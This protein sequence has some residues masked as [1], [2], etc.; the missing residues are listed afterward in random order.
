M[1]IN[2]KKSGETFTILSNAFGDTME[3]P[4]YHENLTTD[5]DFNRF[6]PGTSNWSTVKTFS[7]IESARKWMAKNMPEKEFH[8]LK[9]ALGIK[10]ETV[11]KSHEVK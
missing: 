6:R 4:S 10:N 1:K 11:F 8:I 9:V 5:G 7:S 3:N 2:L